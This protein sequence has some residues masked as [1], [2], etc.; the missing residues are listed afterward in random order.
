MLFR[1]EILANGL[2]LEFFDLS[3]RY[4]GDYWHLCLEVRCRVPL[5]A[6]SLAEAELER[7]RALLGES[8]DY[9][10]RLERMGVPSDEVSRVRQ[11]MVEAFLANARPYLSNPAFPGRL[12]ASRLAA[13]RRG[14]RP[15]LIPR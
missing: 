5:A 13:A 8:I 10:R 7:A 2:I 3:N 6:D 15:S 1:T 9:S 4:F 12:I 11:Q 14:R